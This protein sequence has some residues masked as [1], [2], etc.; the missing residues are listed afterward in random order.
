MQ[1][2]RTGYAFL[3]TDPE[4]H[5]IAMKYRFKYQYKERS[6]RKITIQHIYKFYISYRFVQSSSFN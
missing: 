4:V 5:S 2:L 3:R 1:C 6:T